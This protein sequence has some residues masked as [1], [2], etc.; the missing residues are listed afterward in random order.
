M[1][2]FFTILFSTQGKEGLL[3]TRT[4]RIISMLLC[5]VLLLV[6]LVP[7]V[8]VAAE[9]DTGFKP[10]AGVEYFEDG[11]YLVFDILEEEA[12]T[13][14]TFLQKLLNLLKK[15]FAFLRPE[16]AQQ[17]VSKI[18]YAEYNDA[19]GK[20]LWSISLSADFTYNGK[21]SACTN[22]RVTYKIYDSDWKNISS[23]CSKSAAT[24]TGTFSM[25][26][27]KLGVPLK[28]I[29]KTLTLT[30]DASGKVS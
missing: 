23:S 24:A 14:A 4:K 7:C 18:K 19:N 15:I 17:T 3:M 11:S 25:R 26:Q 8:S 20:R 1:I 30:C 21:T 6:P 16:P 12:Y 9:E 27:Y 13:S 28:L 29:E 22:A 5:A 2:P 10:G